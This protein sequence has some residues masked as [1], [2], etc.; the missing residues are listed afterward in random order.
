MFY[1]HSPSPQQRPGKQTPN[2]II[3]RLLHCASPEQTSIQQ[4]DWRVIPGWVNSSD[5]LMSGRLTSDT[6]WR[7][8]AAVT[9]TSRPVRLHLLVCIMDIDCIISEIPCRAGYSSS[10]CSVAVAG[11]LGGQRIT[12]RWGGAGRWADVRDDQ[13]AHIGQCCLN[14]LVVVFRVYK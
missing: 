13:R 4:T 10:F 8:Q 7:W 6:L 5:R 2:V 11:W 12:G 3:S 14:I 1:D 9:V